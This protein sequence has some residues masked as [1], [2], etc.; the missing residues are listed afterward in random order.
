[1]N[2]VNSELVKVGPLSVTIV[3]GKPKVANISQ[4]SRI[5]WVVVILLIIFTFTHFEFAS[6]AIR[7]MWP[8]NGPA[9]CTHFHGSSG[10]SQGKRGALADCFLISASICD[11]QTQDRAFDFICAT[12]TCVSSCNKCN[13]FVCKD[14]GIITL[15]PRKIQ[16]FSKL[17]SFLRAA[18]ALCLS[19]DFAGHPEDTHWNTA[20]NVISSW[21]S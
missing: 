21:V 17:S 1:M 7:Y 13:T 18:N 2:N 4:S 15:V 12:P 11:H 16:P 14:D 9:K 6:V 8:K 20:F 3:S 5:V 19:F 10:H